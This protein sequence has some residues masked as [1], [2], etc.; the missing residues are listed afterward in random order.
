M[1]KC[2]VCERQTP[3]SRVKGAFRIRAPGSCLR[4][5]SG[6]VCAMWEDVDG[7]QGLNVL[8]GRMLAAATGPLRRAPLADILGNYGS[9][10]ELYV[11]HVQI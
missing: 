8:P 1:L 2:R 3:P 7:W 6:N 4:V 11:S 10:M 5:N 9:E